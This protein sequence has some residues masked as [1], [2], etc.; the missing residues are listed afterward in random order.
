MESYQGINE[1]AV[2]TKAN[3]ITYINAVSHAGF[4]YTPELVEA[5]DIEKAKTAI[6]KYPLVKFGACGK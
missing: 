3:E 6:A 5:K 2:E 1:I 4:S